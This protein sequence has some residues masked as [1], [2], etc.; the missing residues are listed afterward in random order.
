MS[1][2]KE[3]LFSV[4]AKDFDF[5]YTKGTGKG[6]QK[7]NKTE[8]AVHC[9]HKDSGARGYSDAT[10]SQHKNKIDAFAKCIETKE[11]KAW[12]RIETAKRMGLLKQAEE[13]AQRQMRFINVEMLKD[14]EW[15]PYTEETE[16]EGS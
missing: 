6:G 15:V 9:K 13:E 2:E 7:R 3:L 1:K 10:R 12:H 8:T 4:T 5:S 16:N 14:G 11:F